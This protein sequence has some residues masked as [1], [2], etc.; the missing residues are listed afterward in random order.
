[1]DNGTGSSPDSV[2]NSV[3]GTDGRTLCVCA[4]ADGWAEECVWLCG[5]VGG[6]VCVWLTSCLG[7]CTTVS[8]LIYECCNLKIICVTCQSAIM[9]KG[10]NVNGDWVKY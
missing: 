7:G 4:C 5:W 3:L 10:F 2:G 9:L 8:G 1:M 6:G